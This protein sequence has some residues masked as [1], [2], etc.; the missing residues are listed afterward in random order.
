[1]FC[2]NCGTKNLEESLFCENCGTKLQEASPVQQAN[3]ATPNAT[4]SAPAYQAAGGAVA[5]KNNTGNMKALICLGLIALLVIGGV[6]AAC[7]IF[8]SS[9]KDPVEYYEKGCNQANVN[10]FIK[11]YPKPIQELAKMDSDAREH[12]SEGANSLQNSF[13]VG[14][15][16]KMKLVSKT[17]L[18]SEEI[19]DY[20]ERLNEVVQE[21]YEEMGRNYSKWIDI[22]EGYRGEVSL[23][24]TYEDG[25]D[26]STTTLPLVKID[27][28]WYTVY[29][30]GY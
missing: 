24:V 10:T 5:V 18:T 12:F 27:G 17:P 16:V 26:E 21:G 3:P 30:I 8:G 6:F 23:T 19:M 22:E 25:I 13:G 1:M 29:N 15:K 20:E 9:P 28:K 11:A 2:P 14:S 7:S 4:W